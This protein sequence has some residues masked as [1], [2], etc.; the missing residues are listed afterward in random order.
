[1]VFVLF[2]SVAPKACENFRALCTGEKGLGRSGHPLHYKGC[3]FFNVTPGFWCQTGDT[4]R[5]DGTG[6][7]SIYGHPFE[8]ELCV[9]A[10]TL[11]GRRKQAE[12][13]E[14]RRAKLEAQAKNKKRSWGFG[15]RNKG[16]KKEEPDRVKF[17]RGR[18]VMCNSGPH[19]NR[20]QFAI[21]F[22]DAPWLEGT[23]TVFGTLDE[24]PGPNGTVGDGVGSGADALLRK[25]ERT[26][27]SATSTSPQTWGDTEAKK[28]EW[29][30][31]QG[32]GQMVLRERRERVGHRYQ[33]SMGWEPAGGRIGSAHGAE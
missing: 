4:T 28:S 20:S 12:E 27:V 19:S 18:L 7:E 31:I 22:D 30:T 25:M 1:M 17:S 9:P 29:L 10:P 26:G 16:E 23:A 21:L 6:G 2:P 5:D 33:Y 32:C 24:S 11:E 13:A 8:D 14:A 3:V 15:G